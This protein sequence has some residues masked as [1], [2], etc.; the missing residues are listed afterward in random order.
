[1]VFVT[2]DVKGEIRSAGNG[3]RQGKSRKM[4]TKKSKKETELPTDGCDSAV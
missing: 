1:V 4:R 3:R 2:W